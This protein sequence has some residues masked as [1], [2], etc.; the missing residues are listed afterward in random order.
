MF[1]LANEMTC[2]LRINILLFLTKANTPLCTKPILEQNIF[3]SMYLKIYINY[4]FIFWSFFPTHPFWYFLGK[5]YNFFVTFCGVKSGACYCYGRCVMPD[6]RNVYITGQTI[7]INY[8]CYET[9]F[10]FLIKTWSSILLNWRRC[11]QRYMYC[12][13]IFCRVQAS[14]QKMTLIKYSVCMIE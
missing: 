10:W 11:W 7:A 4:Y 12:I 1:P 6:Q 2:F 14:W 8:G 9:A 3:I 5:V 13:M